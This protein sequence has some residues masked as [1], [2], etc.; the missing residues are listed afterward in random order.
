VYDAAQLR[1]RVR[2]MVVEERQRLGLQGP[3]RLD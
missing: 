2:Q 1:A 3:E